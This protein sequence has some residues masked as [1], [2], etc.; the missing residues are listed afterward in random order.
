MD[1]SLKMG[2]TRVNRHDDLTYVWIAPGT[3]RMGCSPVDI[4]CHDD[5]TPQQVT[6]THGF[7]IGQAEVTARAF[8]HYTLAAEAAM[9]KSPD[10][11][12]NWKGE[13]MPISNVSW[14]AASAYCT[15][16]GGRL[17]TET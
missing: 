12:P 9:P 11:N 15:W 7:W 5:D 6:L 4:A 16:T 14:S 10:D 2:Q 8:R 17:P 13:S 1:T 3:Y